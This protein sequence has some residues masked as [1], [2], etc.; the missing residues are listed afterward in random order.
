[1]PNIELPDGKKLKFKEKVS[2]V[3][4]AETISKSLAK[5]ALLMSVDGDLRDLNFQVEKDSSLKIFTSKDKEG[6]ETIRHDTAH[7]LA[8][9][10]QE[11][12]PGTQVTIG[13]VIDDG[14]YYDFSRKEPFT[15]NDLK[16]IEQK[17]MEIVDRNE[18]THREVWNRQK[19]IEHFKKIG[20]K[21]KSEII[22]DIPDGEEVSIYFHGKWHDLC[23]G[24]HLPST[25]K[26]G[27]NFKL[28]KVAGAYWRGDSKNE[29]L[30]RIYGTAWTTKKELDEYLKRIEEA[31]K[32]DHRKLG[33]EMDL[34]HF[35][36]ESPGSVFWHEKGWSLFQKLISYMRAKQNEAGYKEINTPEILDRTLWEKSGHW[37]KF[38]ANMYTSTTPDEKIFAIKPMNCPGC[39][40]VYNQGLKSYRDL[41]LK[42]SEFGKVHRYEP[43][44]ALHGLL[45]VRAFTQDDAHIFCTED[46]ITEECLSVTNLILEIYKDLGFENVILKYSDRPEV[47]V[48]DDHVWDKSEAALLKAVKASK[49]EYSINKG[50]GAFYGPKIEFVLRDAIGRDWQCGT[51]Q[52]DLNLPERLGASFVDKDGSKKV[53][54]MLHRALF[55][56]LE[57]FIGILIENY[58]G[59]LPFWISPLPVMVIPVSED[60][61]NYAKEV[62]KKINNIG[63]NSE[64]DLKNHNLN[65][66]IREHSLS[67]IPLL[68]ICGKKEVDSNTVTIRRLDSNKQ[69]NMEL[70]TFLKKFAALNKAPLN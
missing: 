26:I 60:F 62:N 61:D 41:P 29:M 28:T 65:Y 46:Q 22:N 3:K 24:P 63:I 53:P 44:G 38:G 5:E 66:K 67:K 52:V 32:R 49:L 56:S 55:G 57:R 4:V 54:V 31:E 14:F 42:M 48:G 58:A 20:E 7:I 39:V 33:K 70:K 59:K 2:G 15:E 13:P 10:V 21:Y 25:G 43:S 18:L 64:V 40:Q 50:E 68:L 23:R 16:K 12:F 36:E 37:E 11:L 27:K 30:Q 45:R 6:L 69:E 8:M 1:M 35:R 34:F 9:A 19:A 47:R 51:L 17:M